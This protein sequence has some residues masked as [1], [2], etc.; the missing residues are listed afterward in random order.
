MTNH[1]RRLLVASIIM[2]STAVGLAACGGDGSG[3][4]DPT[5][6]AASDDSSATPTPTEPPEPTSFDDVPTKALTYHYSSSD[7]AV[8]LK[9]MQVQY[10]SQFADTPAEPGTKFMV[11]FTAMRPKL[12]DRG[13]NHLQMRELY[14][15]FQPA[16]TGCSSPSHVNNV[17]TCFITNKTSVMPIAMDESD[18]QSETWMTL[19]LMGIDL[20]A[21]VDY[22]EP[23]VFQIK[24]GSEAKDGYQLC[25]NADGKFLLG[26]DDELAELPCVPIP[27]P[28]ATGN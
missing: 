16:G 27:T 5:T 6:S 21:G 10:F 1:V 28:D 26:T 14:L 18:W 7:F 25:G 9:P 24:D 3:S 22:R 4:A 11:V 20:D 17:E 15:R 13:V 23:L 2:L 19:D 12:A 8:M